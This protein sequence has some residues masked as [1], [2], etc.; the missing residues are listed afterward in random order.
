M[1][2]GGWGWGEGGG[3][4]VRGQ[5]LNVI[6]SKAARASTIV[7]KAWR[8][9]WAFVHLRGG[10]QITAER[11]GILDDMISTGHACNIQLEVQS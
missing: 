1:C 5:A 2:I 10:K 8:A 3:Q 11:R 6:K 7:P 9:M 4:T